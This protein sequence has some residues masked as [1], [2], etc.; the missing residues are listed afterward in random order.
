[1]LT[2]K[3]TQKIAT[4]AN[5]RAQRSSGRSPGARLNQTPATNTAKEMGCASAAPEKGRKKK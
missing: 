1:M 2:K 5:V 4:T 3:A